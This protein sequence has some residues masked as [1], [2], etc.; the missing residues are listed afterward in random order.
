MLYIRREPGQIFYIND[1][2]V[3]TASVGTN[4][5]T[6]E[7]K[8]NR[9]QVDIT[10]HHWIGETKIILFRTLGRQADWRFSAPRHIN[11]VREELYGKYIPGQHRQ[12]INGVGESSKRGYD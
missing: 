1:L 10:D 11:I 5:A 3:K 2:P 6:L 7:Y 9:Y 4:S 12:P 8:G